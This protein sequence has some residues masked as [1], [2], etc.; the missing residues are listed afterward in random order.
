MN[1]KTFIKLFALLS[2]VVFTN[3]LENETSE[4][5]LRVLEESKEVPQENKETNE[6]KRELNE[7]TIEKKQENEN[8]NQEANE[9]PAEAPKDGE[10]RFLYCV[11]LN[12]PCKLNSQ[13]C[14]KLCKNTCL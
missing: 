13:C 12:L 6:E 8:L 2:L 3:S 7:V 1:A 10:G 11:P 9:A 14:S 5:N 4:N